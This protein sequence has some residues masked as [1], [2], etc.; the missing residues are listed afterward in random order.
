MSSE[1]SVLAA[2]TDDIRLF[3]ATRTLVD[4]ED[5]AISSDSEHG[6]PHFP[7][8]LGQMML[9][10]LLL[11]LRKAFWILIWL[12]NLMVMVKWYVISQEGGTCSAPTTP[13]F[14]NRI[15]CTLHLLSISF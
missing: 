1:S 11:L 13:C 4:S 12:V 10:M 2:T 9:L 3:S 6:F 5:S 8:H 7:N 15:S 14:E